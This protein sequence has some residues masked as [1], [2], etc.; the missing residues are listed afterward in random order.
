M[1]LLTKD[2]RIS[3]SGSTSLILEEFPNIIQ[4]E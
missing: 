4:T 1:A 3:F 2:V